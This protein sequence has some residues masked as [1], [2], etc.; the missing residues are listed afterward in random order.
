MKIPPKPS[1]MPAD[2]AKWRKQLNLS[3]F[4]NA[5]YEYRDLQRFEGCRDI[6][7]VGPAQGLDVQILRWRGYEV[8]TFDIDDK[9][10]PDVVGSIHDL[11]AFGDK[12]F[13]AAVISHVL[14]HLAEPYLDP[15]LREISRV[16]RH[17]L[18]YLP[19]HGAHLQLR[20]RSNVQAL[21]IS[22][23]VDIFNYLKGT[24]GHTPRYMDGQH[25][26][27]VGMKGFRVRD[28]MKRMRRYFDVL[29]SYRNRDWLPSYNFVL[30]SKE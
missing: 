7:V 2:T 4:V 1:V 13:D 23:I 30:R 9:F 28:L 29:D 26:W 14:E 3:N 16:S 10:E 5:Y 18:I 24:D 20:A 27:E 15:A 25:Y 12:R 8:V 11:S 17:S 6:L 19:V 21:D 22:F